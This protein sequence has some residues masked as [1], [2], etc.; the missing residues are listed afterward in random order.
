MST[1]SA[2]YLEAAK[3][4]GAWLAS[5]LHEG[6]IGVPPQGPEVYYKSPYALSLV[7]RLAEAN[8]LLNWTAQ[9][10]VTKH[11]IVRTAD[12]RSMGV[13]RY[14]WLLQ[15]AWRAGRF[16]LALGFR[17]DVLRCQAPCGGFFLQ[18]A[19]EETVEAA[20]SGWGGMGALYSG[21][22]EAARRAG[23]AL[24]TMLADQPDPNRLYTS[25]SPEGETLTG[26]KAV[27]LDA[28]KSGQ[29]Y[30]RAGIPFLFLMRLYQA[31]DESRY[32]E[33]SQQIFDFLMRSAPDAFGH[34]TAGKSM[35]AAALLWAETRDNRAKKAAE[36]QAHFFLSIQSPNGYWT[37]PARDD[38]VHRVDHTA[39]FTIF[40][41]E[42][43]AALGT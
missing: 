10:A 36:G 12:P 4:G 23:D 8:H 27:Y 2:N 16:D 13:Y 1:E 7:G 18:P 32:L 15:G 9:H 29:T 31:T 20:W 41:T 19:G 28:T 33:T 6:G 21:H 22:V 40:M 35:L 39:E 43:A 38:V 30:W 14:S 11:G 42:T 26:E 17:N 24:C 37:S 5:Q 34:L 3:R 25:M